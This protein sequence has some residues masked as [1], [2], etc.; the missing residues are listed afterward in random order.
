MR[1]TVSI[2]DDIGQEIERVANEEGISISEFYAR[3]AEE[4]LKQIRR[5]RAIEAFD[6]RAGTIEIHGD[7][8][9]A[10]RK[11]RQEDPERV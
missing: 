4:R 9:E 8:D 7:F 3:A 1:H 6:R 5:R 2:R 11:I 10:L